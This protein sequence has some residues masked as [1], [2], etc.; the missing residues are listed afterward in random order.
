MHKTQD[1]ERGERLR[2]G[3]PK[4]SEK[5][6]NASAILPC[7]ARILLGEALVVFGQNFRFLGFVPFKT[8]DKRD[9]QGLG[10]MRKFSKLLK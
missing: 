3:F 1:G 6:D 7:S 5:R 9:F 4:H 2:T 8:A 10:F